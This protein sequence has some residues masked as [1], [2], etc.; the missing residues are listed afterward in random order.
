MEMLV[1]NA[2]LTEIELIRYEEQ[3]YKLVKHFR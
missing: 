2:G 3:D 1:K